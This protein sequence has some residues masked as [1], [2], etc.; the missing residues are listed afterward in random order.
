MFGQMAEREG[1]YVPK[2][3]LVVVWGNHEYSVA[4]TRFG[5]CRGFVRLCGDYFRSDATRAVG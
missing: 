2:N 4:L 5:Y 1:V 3:L